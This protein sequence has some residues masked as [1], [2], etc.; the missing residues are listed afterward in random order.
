MFNGP[1]EEFGYFEDS[2]ESTQSERLRSFAASLRNGGAVVQSAQ[3][4]PRDFQYPCRAACNCW[5]PLHP[6]ELHGTCTH[7]AYLHTCM[8][9]T[10]HIFMAN[11]IALRPETSNPCRDLSL[12]HVQLARQ[13]EV[14]LKLRCLLT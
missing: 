11:N 1:L 7:V 2:G 10:K 12:T 3:G 13:S 8:P 5:S 6:P 14:N 4:F 9:Y